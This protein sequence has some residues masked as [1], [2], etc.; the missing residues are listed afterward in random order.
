[1][2]LI[3]GVFAVAF[4]SIACEAVDS[5]A[6]DKDSLTDGVAAGNGV[7]G[8]SLR[9]ENVGAEGFNVFWSGALEG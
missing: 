1:M 3:E 9:K 5:G 7:A 4:G 6:F 8:L 2:T